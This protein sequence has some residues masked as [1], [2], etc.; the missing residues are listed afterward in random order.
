MNLME[1]LEKMITDEGRRK[2]AWILRRAGIDVDIVPEEPETEDDSLSDYELNVF[3]HI[4]VLLMDDYEYAYRMAL[5]FIEELKRRGRFR[6]A[7]Y[8]CQ[9][10]GDEIVRREILK[11]GMVHYERVGDFRN[12]M[13]F[14][15]MLG[16]LE[17]YEIYKNLYELYKSTDR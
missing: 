4:E 12:A 8:L 7:L 5:R 2:A 17:R 16:D 1:W 6:S 3:D 15:R 11:E 10:I 13:E 9:M 14:A